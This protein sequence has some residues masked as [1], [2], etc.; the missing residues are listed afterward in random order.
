MTATLPD[1]AP[2]ALTGSGRCRVECL[3]GRA[4]IT[5]EAAGRDFALAPGQHLELIDGGRIVVS[6]VNGPSRV[7]LR[8]I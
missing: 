2:L 6:A 3:S 5:A 1:G 4:W 7:C 8:W